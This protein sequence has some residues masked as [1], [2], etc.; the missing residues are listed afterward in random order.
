MRQ[1]HGSRR[2]L[3]GALLGGAAGTALGQV[4]PWPAIG[5]AGGGARTAGRWLWL[6]LVSADVARSAAFYRQAFGWEIVPHAGAGGAYQTM[7]ANGRAQ[8]GLLAAPTGARGARWIPLASGNPAVVAARAQ[9]RGGAVL[10]P[11]QTAAGRGELAVLAAPEGVA[12]GVLQAA[13]GDPPDH[14]GAVN[15]WLWL[16]LWSR[17]PGR[18]TSFFSAVFGYAVTAAATPG[19]YMLNAAGRARAGVMALPDAAL[20]PAWLPY[21]RVGDIGAS[22]RR[23]QGAGARLL[24]APRAHH[25]SQVAVLVDPQGAPLALA[26]WRPA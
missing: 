12:F 1:G 17:D 18:A 13:G 23:A 3:L 11:P 21:L 7:R 25:R 6:E 19:A 4:L 24:V 8:A 2:V 10:T 15:E 22:V 9:E 5:A 14:L 20:A 26:E 16:E